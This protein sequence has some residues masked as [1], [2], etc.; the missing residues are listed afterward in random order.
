MSE[1]QNKFYLNARDDRAARLRG[2]RP[3]GCAWRRAGD[4]KILKSMVSGDG[5]AFLDFE[6]EGDALAAA[7][8]LGGVATKRPRASVAVFTDGDALRGG[9]VG[10]AGAASGARVASASLKRL[11]ARSS[12][13]AGSMTKRHST[14]KAQSSASR[15]LTCV[16]IELQAPPPSSRCWVRS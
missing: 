15:V 9:V 6:G 7:G 3:V 11:R 16:E 5:G 10:V 2:D 12:S 1:L 4:R 14:L 8:G 13:G